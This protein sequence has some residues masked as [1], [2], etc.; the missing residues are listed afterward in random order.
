MVFRRLFELD[1]EDKYKLKANENCHEFLMNDPTSIKALKLKFPDEL[2]KIKELKKI[3]FDKANAQE[4]E[5]EG[6]KIQ[7][8]VLETYKQAFMA[9]SKRA[10]KEE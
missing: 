4:N 5:E 1:Y 8:E 7:G 10:E 3:G 2:T 9:I 6:H